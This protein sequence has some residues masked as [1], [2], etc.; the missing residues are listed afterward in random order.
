[1]SKEGDKEKDREKGGAAN[2]RR[3]VSRSR[4]NAELQAAFAER[5]HRLAMLRRRLQLASAG[6]HAYEEGK[7]SE[8]VRNFHSYLHILE[9]W[10]GVREGK[11]TPAHFDVKT[12]VSEL[13]LISGVYWDLAKLYDRTKSAGKQREFYEYLEKYIAF[14]KG[15]PFQHVGLETLR[16]Y[17]ANDKALHMSDFKNAYRVMGGK[18]SPCFVATSLADVCD[19]RTLPR[20]RTFRDLK[21]RR[22]GPGRA[23]I[24]WY[25]RNGPRMAAWADRQPRF[26]RQAMGIVVDGVGALLNLI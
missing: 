2:V 18:P 4:K 3:S 19:E 22:S 23:F 9:D 17:I 13:L 24:A 14:T 7:I 11:L 10:K 12:D 5:Q 21:L 26:V 25:Y 15:M 20:L 1:M 8:A 6:V 16:K